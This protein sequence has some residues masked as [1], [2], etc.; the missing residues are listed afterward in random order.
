MFD[1]KDPSTWGYAI[2]ALIGTWFGIKKLIR[3]D[4]TEE[5]AAG[6]VI[7][8]NGAGREVVESMKRQIKELTAEVQELRQKVETYMKEHSECQQQNRELNQKLL[9]LADK[10][11]TLE[12][13]DRMERGHL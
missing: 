1:I 12:G 10:V 8:L 13:V 4:Q 7:S 11:A 3:R 5:S 2:A 9:S 6:F